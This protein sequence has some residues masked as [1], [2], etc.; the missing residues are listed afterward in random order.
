MTMTAV[1]PTRATAR[2]AGTFPVTA[3]ATRR[4]LRAV[5]RSPAL[6]ITPF[7]QSL[8][9]L[10]VYA[11]QLGD[12]GSSYL[13]DQSF[14][15]FLLPLIVLT[16]VATGAGA[17]GTMT[18]GDITSGYLDRLRMAHGTATPFLAGTLIATLVA[19]SVQAL[20]TTGGAM[21]V[22]YRPTGWAE[23]FAMV[24]LMLVLG[25]AVAL[26]SIAVAVHTV[27]SSTTGLVPLAFFGL[28]FFTGVFA[29]VEEL[30]GWMQ[31]IATVNPLTYIIDTARELESGTVPSAGPVAV[32]LL[33]VLVVAGLISCA[34]ALHRARRR[35]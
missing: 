19:V 2:G 30:S 21:L 33:L 27:S 20:L 25:L 14:I 15:A 4:S 28:S 31:A 23:T 3:A 32:G 26:F 13:D 11:G 16:G 24:G 34:L 9:F 5:F 29:P 10:L 1:P 35:R 8:F 7:A 22:G 6:L 12:V 17:A 18:L